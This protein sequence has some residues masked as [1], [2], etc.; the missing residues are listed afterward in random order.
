MEVKTSWPHAAWRFR[1]STEKSFLPPPASMAEGR[2]GVGT[3]A[4]RGR[5]GPQ[6]DLAGARH[7]GFRP[8]SAGELVAARDL[9]GRGGARRSRTR[10]PATRAS[11]AA[12]RC[13]Q[14]ARR[15]RCG[16]EMA[17]AR[18]RQRGGE[19][20]AA[21]LERGSDGAVRVRVGRA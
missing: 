15:W 20:A 11:H 9:A 1:E 17:G 21:A 18:Q 14:G 10:G 13:A 3:Q 5:R 19:A 8:P 4:Y 2:G 7:C 12:A 16:G 6:G